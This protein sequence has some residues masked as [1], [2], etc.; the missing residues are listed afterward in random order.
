M[1]RVD[2]GQVLDIA[3]AVAGDLRELYGDRLR[4]V[5]LFGSWARGDADPES[6]IDPMVVLDRVDDV[7]E[8]VDRMEPILWEHTDASGIV[9][10]G[11]PASQADVDGDAK[12]VYARARA[13]GKAVA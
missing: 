13:E 12:P 8:E 6:D 3:R 11:M 7:L 5:L 9:V 10:S 1:T 4:Q 2:S